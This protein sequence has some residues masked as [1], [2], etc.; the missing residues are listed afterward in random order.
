MPET[1][2]LVTNDAVVLGML[3]LILGLIFYTER[4]QH[5]F[6]RRFYRYVPGLLLCYFLPSLL[7]SF[8]VV[9]GDASRLYFVSSRYLLPACLVLLTLS[10]DF[11]AIARL[12]YKAV[13]MFLT[14][15]V[16]IVIG[17][18]LALVA[19]GTIDPTVVGGH[20]S[21]A[22]WRGMATIAGSWIGGGANQTA[23]KEVFQVD[24]ALFSQMVAVDVL[25][26]SVW[27]AVLLF[28]ASRAA[29]IDGRM[30]A[31]TSAI[32]N[33]K[34]RVARFHAEHSRVTTLPDLI[35]IAAIGFGVTG[36]AHA[37]A[38]LIAPWIEIHAP[39]LA[40][41][42]LTS[43]FFWIVV[44]A[45]TAGL[46]LSF[47]P[48]RRLEGA[49]ASRVG[50]AMLYILVASIGMRMDVGAVFRNPGLFAV[51][52]VWIGVHALLLVLVAR[53]LKAPVFYL[54]VGSQANVGGAAS[55]PVV[56]SAFHPTLA[57]VGVLL[58]VLGYSLGTY[59]AWVCGLMMAAVAPQ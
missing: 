32:E 1:Q 51:G 34:A 49:G 58:A 22:V 21:Q 59:A 27:M 31:D 26:A 50:S 16:G 4:S 28:L 40:R 18:P 20:G 29:E 52:F 19:V 30:G 45:T 12:G 5:P 25:C 48:A 47:T 56:A 55:A 7:N 53:L 57:P 43:T 11:V 10:V 13:A 9:D 14:G 41:L 6:W 39:G 3:A 54:A 33:L 17:G 8:G 44:I 23:M 2:P 35:F 38:G 46:A 36:F 37:C 15:T 42:S 24:D